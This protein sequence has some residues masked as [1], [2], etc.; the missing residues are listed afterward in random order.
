MFRDRIE[1]GKKLARLI[2]EK[3]AEFDVVV[4]IP[5]GGV[6]VAATVAK[7]LKVKCY[8]LECKKIPHPINEEVAIGAVCRTA[9]VLDELLIKSHLISSVIEGKVK[10]LQGEVKKR[11]A[12]YKEFSFQVKS[13]LRVVVV[14][15]G[16]AT[17]WTVIAACRYLSFKQCIVSVA[18]PVCAFDSFKRVQME[19]KEVISIEVPL[20]FQAVGQFYTSFPQVTHEQAVDFLKASNV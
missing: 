11:E 19:A 4:G 17:G 16:I 20:D 5:R 12:I 9:V 8:V 14:D 13:G 15:D 1:A 10:K 7:L 18:V 6:I 3:K 2:R